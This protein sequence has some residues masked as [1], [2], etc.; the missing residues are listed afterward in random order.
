MARMLLL[1]VPGQFTRATFEGEA[2]FTRVTFQDTAWFEG[3]TFEGEAQFTRATFQDTAWFEGATFQG[4]AQFTRA[5]F[6]DGRTFQ[7]TATRLVRATVERAEFNRATFEDGATFL[8]TTRFVG[9]TFERAAKFYWATFHGDALFD[10]A[11]FQ[12]VAGFEATFQS[13][14]SFGGAIFQG[15]AWF[16]WATF[17]GDALFGQAIFQGDADFVETIFQDSAWFNLATFERAQELGP[18]LAHN[19]LGLD[20]VQFA[21][22]V[23]IEVSAVSVCCRRSQFPSG[24]QFRL[25]WADV[26]LDDTDLPAPQVSDRSWSWCH[27]FLKVLRARHFIRVRPPRV[28][29]PAIP[30]CPPRALLS[31]HLP[32]FPTQPRGRGLEGDVGFQS[33]LVEASILPV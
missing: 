32:L 30:A 33:Q 6:Q 25:R 31:D 18:L 2:Q 26:L 24:V 22:P 10:G 9:A 20:G 1:P 7:V 15:Q 4:E 28:S 21:Q 12:S 14:A 19:W 27:W 13:M 5:T 17:Y 23:R 8:A 3:A 29:P 16:A 11:T